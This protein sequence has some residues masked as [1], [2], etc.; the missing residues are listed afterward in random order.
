MPLMNGLKLGG[1]S[2]ILKEYLFCNI[3][4]RVKSSGNKVDG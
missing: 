1:F 4:N 2:K 3:L